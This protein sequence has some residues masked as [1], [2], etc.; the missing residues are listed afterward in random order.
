ML[1]IEFSVLNTKVANNGN[2][3]IKGFYNSKN[4]NSNG[5]QPDDHWFKSLMLS[6]LS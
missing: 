5:D 3:A 4:V 6:L 2:V 1:L